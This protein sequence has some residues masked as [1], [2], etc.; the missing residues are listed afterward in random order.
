MGKKITNASGKGRNN[1]QNTNSQ[2]VANTTKNLAKSSPLTAIAAAAPP[3]P[4][5]A[6]A[7]TT[8]T[9]IVPIAIS[10]VTTT[11]AAVVQDAQPNLSTLIKIQ[12]NSKYLPRYSVALSKPHDESL[13]AEELD[14][15]QLELE[16]LLSTVALRYRSLKIEFDSLDREEKNH[17]KND[18]AANSPSTTGK[19]KRDDGSKKSVKDSKALAQSTKMSKLKTNSSNSPAP[20]QHTDDSLDAMPY[21]SSGQNS[22]GQPNQKSLI[23]KNDIPNKFWLSVEPYCMPITQEDTKLLDDLIEEYSEPLVPPIPELGPHYTSRWAAEDLRE[24]LDNSNPNAKANKRFTNA[25]NPDVSSMMKK[26]EKSIGEGITGPLTQRLVAALIDENLIQGG[27]IGDGNAATN[28][29]ND[30]CGE[31]NSSSANRNMAPIASLLK[32]G[33]DVER[34]LKKEL[35]ELGILDISDFPKE[36]DDEVL[37]EIIRVRTELQAISEYNL[38]ELKQ[39]QVAAKEEMK[40]L[41]IK[42]KL[43]LVDQEVNKNGIFS[44]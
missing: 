15:I 35:I 22:T 2:Q 44:F 8:S 3:P 38:S 9:P 41:E 12:E 19:R 7:T 42:R 24:E 40:R 20:S 18:K 36:K 43:D 29:S 21:Y 5:T 31:N 17:K 30:S 32:N 14:A 23:P 39:L 1:Y 28:D 16:R 10:T 27:I 4:P 26:G 13:P 34:R 6:T 11:S 37:N 33:I 25:A